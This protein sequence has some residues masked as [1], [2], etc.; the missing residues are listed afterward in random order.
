MAKDAAS[1]GGAQPEKSILPPLVRGRPGPV[2]P[3]LPQ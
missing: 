2:R 1:R 3:R